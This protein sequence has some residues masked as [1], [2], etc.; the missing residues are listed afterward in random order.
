VNRIIDYTEKFPE[1]GDNMYWH[2]HVPCNQMLLDS[3][4][5]L[6]YTKSGCIKLLIERIEYLKRIAP[7]ETENFKIVVCISIPCL[8]DSQI[9]IFKDEEYYNSFFIRETRE[10]KWTLLNRQQSF[11]DKWNLKI[12][13]YFEVKGFLEEIYDEE[14]LFVR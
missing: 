10:Q 13:E 9:I 6:S 2:L 12:P 1:I 14:Q 7:V 11:V 5:T 3:K 4:V 8:W